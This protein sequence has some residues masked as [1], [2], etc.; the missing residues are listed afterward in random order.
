MRPSL[1]AAGR[2]AAVSALTVGALPLGGSVHADDVRTDTKL[3]GFTVSVEAAPLRILMDD[4]K[5]QIPH[6][7]DTAVLEADPNY[8]LASV[9]AGPNA[10]AVTSTLWPGNLLGEGLA[11]VAPGAPAYP[12]KGEARYPDK[13]YTANGVDGGSL[14]GARAEGLF[15]TAT[16]DG[17]PTNKPG[18]VT[19]GS[20]TSTSTATVDAKDVARGTAVSAAHD[21]NL[22][23]GLIH[24]GN[25]TTTLETHADGTKLA[26]SGTTTVSGLTIAGQGF[27]VDDK[28]LHAGPASNGLPPLVTPSQLAAAGITA[29]AISQTTGKTT[30]GINRAAS[31][32]VI[33]VD[34]APL[35][36]AT[37]GPLSPLYDA[38]RSVIGDI[39]PDHLPAGT[40]GNLYYLLK[41]T[42]NITF[43]FGAATASSAATLPISFS[44]PPP[45]FP[46]APGGFA[47]GP[48]PGGVLP[49]NPGSPTT[50]GL[51]GSLPT[52]APPGATGPVVQAPGTAPAASSSA[53]G[54]GGIGALWPLA[55]LAASGLVGWLLLRLLGVTG[56]ALGLGCRMGA[57]TTVPN[58]RSVTA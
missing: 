47:S 23:N 35:R 1:R 16:A 38:L 9:A 32:L 30:N 18:Q 5:L 56:G 39:P 58:L 6:P 50:P 10:R 42:P 33:R 8:T 53:T 21:V 2:V 48:V 55:A 51:T 11:Q 34:T 57:P 46:S 40:Q 31:G 41:A 45:S 54:G 19:M 4:P 37:N 26:S 17:T 52:V 13:P 20:A 44:F 28:G 43:Q 27:S 15:A 24:I 12:L 25:V 49:G 7:P 29:Q 3:A 22:L 36:A 14:S